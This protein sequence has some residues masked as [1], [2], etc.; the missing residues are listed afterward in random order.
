MNAVYELNHEIY[1]KRNDG[2]EDYAR[3]RKKIE[4]INTCNCCY[5]CCQQKMGELGVRDLGMTLRFLF[6]LSLSKAPAFIHS[7]PKVLIAAEIYI[8]KESATPKKKYEEKKNLF[9]FVA[10][11]AR[12]KKYHFD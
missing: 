1:I 12:L 11:S 8:Y 2:W 9:T 10:H 3:T 4:K 7:F 6:I 5:W